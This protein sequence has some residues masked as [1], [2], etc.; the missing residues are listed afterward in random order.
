MMVNLS[1]SIWRTITDQVK[2]MLIYTSAAQ[3]RAWFLLSTPNKLAINTGL[4][5]LIDPSTDIAHYLPYPV[6]GF[7][8]GQVLPCKL[9][10]F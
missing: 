3:V 5:C 6:A 4:I 8:L 1:R 9:V 7:K 10:Y 2:L